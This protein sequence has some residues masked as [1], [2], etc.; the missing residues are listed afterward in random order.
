MGEK[1]TKEEAYSRM[2]KLV[3]NGVHNVMHDFPD[4]DENQVVALTSIFYN[5]W[6]GYI[7]IKRDG[8]WVVNIPNFCMVKGR[9]PEEFS[10]LIKR[11][12]EER[13]LIF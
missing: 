1:I 10:G 12:A 8:M 11:R 6:S 4:A 7:R 3:S 9:N 5:C 13:I 2:L